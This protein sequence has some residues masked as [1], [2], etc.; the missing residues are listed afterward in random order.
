MKNIVTHF[1]RTV[2]V[3]GVEIKLILGKKDLIQQSRTFS[4]IM[5]GQFK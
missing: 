5:I 2:E 4:L 3:N 1:L